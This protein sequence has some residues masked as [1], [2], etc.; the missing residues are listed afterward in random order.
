ML[1]IIISSIIAILI[2]FLELFENRKLIKTVLIALIFFLIAL[3]TYIQV[4]EKRKSDSEKVA[5]DSISNVRFDS[6]LK[7]F[8]E[9]SDRMQEQNQ[10]EQEAFEYL[11][12]EST[13]IIDSL[14]LITTLSSSNIGKSNEQLRSLVKVKDDLG[15]LNYPIFPVNIFLVIGIPTSSLITDKITEQFGEPLKSELWPNLFEMH[16]SQ[17]GFSFKL[18]PRFEWNNLKEERFDPEKNVLLYPKMQIAVIDSM[19]NK[20]LEMIQK[21]FS[22][23]DKFKNI[24][25]RVIWNKDTI[26]FEFKNF[27]FESFVLGRNINSLLDFEKIDLSLYIN[28]TFPNDYLGVK[29][30][31]KPY[32]SRLKLQFGTKIL[33]ELNSP[34]IIEPQVRRAQYRNFNAYQLSFHWPVRNIN[35]FQKVTE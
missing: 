9:L 19:K 20:N 29:D 27:K 8:Q 1:Y 2:I 3:T 18:Y 14:T 21:P 13:R 35:D 31:L 7:H 16:K 6:N 25:N 10:K 32:I 23:Y 15:K 33:Y 22:E 4:Q 11:Q 30:N 5:N 34:Q 26:F 17:P 28:F 24:P 12:L